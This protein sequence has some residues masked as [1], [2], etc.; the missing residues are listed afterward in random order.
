MHKRL[1][2]VNTA[3]TMVRLRRR[4]SLLNVVQTRLKVTHRL[5]L[6]HDRSVSDEGPGRHTVMRSKRRCLD[7]IP[8][9][10]Q[11]VYVKGMKLLF[12]QRAE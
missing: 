1:P 12:I 5:N 9:V 11:D 6:A 3:D 10:L 7:R 4:D 2:Y 8:F